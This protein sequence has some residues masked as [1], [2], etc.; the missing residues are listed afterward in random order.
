MLKK[1]NTIVDGYDVKKIN[2]W[3]NPADRTR[4]VASCTHN[5]RVLVLDRKGDYTKVRTGSGK[6]GW[7]N[8]AFL[9]ETD[10]QDLPEYYTDSDIA[11]D[12]S[13]FEK[14]RYYVSDFRNLI[15]RTWISRLFRKLR[16]L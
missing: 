2:L 14:E 1:I 5:E 16:S 4:I 12:K 6:M 15:S 9:V 10:A 13:F 3:P 11:V 8:T 7:C